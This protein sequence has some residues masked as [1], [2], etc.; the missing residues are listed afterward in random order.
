M[1]PGR[2]KGHQH[3]GVYCIQNGST[4]PPNGLSAD[5]KVMSLSADVKVMGLP[6]DVKVM[7]LYA[8]VK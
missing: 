5:V 4:M 7:G 1:T 3:S 8:D 6:A 2:Q